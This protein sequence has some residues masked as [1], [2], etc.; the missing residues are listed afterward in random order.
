MRECP[1]CCAALHL[2]QQLHATGHHEAQSITHQGSIDLAS[3]PSSAI[4]PTRTTVSIHGS[5]VFSRNGDRRVL[6]PSRHAIHPL[7]PL[8]A[9]QLD[10]CFEC[11]LKRVRETAIWS[12]FPVVCSE[13]T[14]GCLALCC[15]LLYSMPYLVRCCSKSTRAKRRVQSEGLRNRELFHRM[16]ECDTAAILFISY[17][18][19]HLA[20]LL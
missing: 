12:V 10:G 20:R 5:Q 9:L 14:R 16:A 4:L 17:T 3:S 15:S 2:V 19:A 6:S 1:V 11:V 18:E 8:P 13:C 7:V